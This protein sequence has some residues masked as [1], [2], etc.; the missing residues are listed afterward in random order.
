[1]IPKIIH[2][3]WYQGCDQIPIKFNQNITSI[4]KYSKDWHYK[5]WSSRELYKQCIQYSP[6][7]AKLF[8]EYKYL[9]Q[10]VDLARYV[11]LYNFGG[12]YVDIDCI[13]L[14]SFNK[15]PGLDTKELIVSETPTNEFESFLTTGNSKIKL[16][17]NGIILSTKHN[18][19]IKYLI[20]TI[21]EFGNCRSIYNPLNW[22]KQLCIFRSTGPYM[23][24]KVINQFKND[25]KIMILPHEYFEP[26]YSMD[27][28]CTIGKNTIIYHKHELSWMNAL[29]IYV[30]KGYLYA[31]KNI[32]T[33][34]LILTIL[35]IIICILVLI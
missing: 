33:T 5:C 31:K 16:L 20:D 6:A 21:I 26:C 27:P 28:S 2:Q 1:M 19:Y 9:H 10:K 17:N 24:T 14:M 12:M 4:K 34:F 11:L 13:A 22:C 29:M 30:I 18:K 15:I 8:Q 35:I 7:C 3:I 32:K 23:F 25:D